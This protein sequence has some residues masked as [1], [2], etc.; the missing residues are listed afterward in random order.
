MSGLSLLLFLILVGLELDFCAVGVWPWA[1]AD[2][3]GRLTVA[4]GGH[5]VDVE[6]SSMFLVN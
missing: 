6:S 3:R 5:A 4:L 2:M 1:P